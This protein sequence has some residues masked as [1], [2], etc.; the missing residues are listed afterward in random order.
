MSRDIAPLG[1]RMPAELK[2][3]IEQAAKRTGRSMNAE[4]VA[5]LQSSLSGPADASD[6]P[7]MFTLLAFVTSLNAGMALADALPAAKRRT[8]RN[9]TLLKLTADLFMKNGGSA[10]SLQ[11]LTAFSDKFERFL[12]QERQHTQKGDK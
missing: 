6:A 8:D 11:E 4:I 5:R 1:L 9:A 2:T 3:Q 10:P 7:F 12:E